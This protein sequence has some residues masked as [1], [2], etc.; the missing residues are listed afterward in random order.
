MKN[1]SKGG[2]K[3][4]LRIMDLYSDMSC[5]I[6]LKKKSELAKSTYDFII[7]LQKISNVQIK[8]VR[9]ENAGENIKLDELC[10]EK[11]LGIKFQYTS[12][13]TPQKNGVDERRFATSYGRIRAMMNGAGLTGDL[14]RSL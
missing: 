7:D 2:K 14:R 13:N 11:G 6:F 3:F 8:H 10:K 4:W 1:E 5:S 9:C 12:P